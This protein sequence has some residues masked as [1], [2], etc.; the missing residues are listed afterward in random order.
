MDLFVDGITT[1]R[2][3]LRPRFP[4][5]AAA[6][7]DKKLFYRERNEILLLSDYQHGERKKRVA[8][9]FGRNRPFRPGQDVLTCCGLRPVALPST[10]IRSSL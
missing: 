5:V 3:G 4:V 7:T 6:T 2:T 1:Q 8:L 10:L 9:K